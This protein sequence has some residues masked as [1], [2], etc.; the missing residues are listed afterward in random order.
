MSLSRWEDI[1]TQWITWRQHNPV[2]I[3]WGLLIAGALLYYLLVIIPINNLNFALV[4]D[5]ANNQEQ[6]SWISKAGQEIIRIR[7]RTPK[8][9]TQ[10]TNETTFNLIN[11]AINSEGWNNLVTELKQADQGRVQVTFSSIPF[12]NLI[13]WLEKLNEKYDILIVDANMQKIEPGIV[14]AALVFK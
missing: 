3:K 13:E 10:K 5:I 8:K 1:K 9:I 14:Q 7:Q 4:N 6:A 2:L 11:Q 12:S